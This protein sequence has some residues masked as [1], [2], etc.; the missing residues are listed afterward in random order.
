MDRV[1]GWFFKQTEAT[2]TYHQERCLATKAT[3][4]R[5]CA[6]ECPHDAIRVRRKVE[7]DPIDCTGC[8]ICV[9]ACPSLALTPRGSAVPSDVT[10]RCSQVAG[11]APSVTCLAR[12]LPTDLLRLADPDGVVRLGRGDCADCAV[13]APDV[14]ERVEATAVRARAIAAVL[15]RELQVRVEHTERV[16]A[17]VQD[18]SMSRRD[19][20]RSSS[21]SAKRVT[22]SALAPL[23][24]L[25]GPEQTPGG[26]PALPTDWVDTLALY[27]AAGLE[28]ETLVPARLPHVVD[29][30][31]FCPACTAACPTDAIQR[32][33]EDDGA[34]TLWLE[35]RRCV[36]CDA[37]Q[38]VCPVKVI[39]MDQPVTWERLGAERTELA[40]R[41]GEGPPGTRPR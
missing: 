11:D 25:A 32:R 1:L 37:C 36:G 2:P 13:G 35:P 33:F 16:D 23:E 30:C 10:L 27:D 34:T 14:P 19:L 31:L 5:I 29:G 39:R 41:G 7:I 26:R 9:S 24:K 12:L 15:S 17:V 21:V 4:C 3:G 6:D 22:A 18:R 20:F 40:R 28:S 8:G 38:Q